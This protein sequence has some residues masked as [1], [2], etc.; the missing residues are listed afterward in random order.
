[1]V[2]FTDVA[3]TWYVGMVCVLRTAYMKSYS[4]KKKRTHMPLLTRLPSPLPRLQHD[5][6]TSLQH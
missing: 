4:T 2:V 6:P 1:M 5:T 3:S